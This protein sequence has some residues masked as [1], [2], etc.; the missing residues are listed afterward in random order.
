MW[1]CN[2]WTDK[3]RKIKRGAKEEVTVED[4]LKLMLNFFQEIDKEIKESYEKLSILDLKQ[5]DILHYIEATTL[6]ASGY[7]KVGK[8]LKQVRTERREIKNEIEKLELLQ[9]LTNK[10]NNKMIQGD[11]IQTLKGL[12][13]INKRQAEPKY[14]CKT[15]ILT[16]L[17]AKDEQIQKQKSNSRW[18][19]IWQ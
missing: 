16:R 12:N 17:E 8:L 5:Q 10:Y 19:R 7:S 1:I 11:I 13:T 3:Y 4:L 18:K 14:T 9:K 2:K 6:N 15:D